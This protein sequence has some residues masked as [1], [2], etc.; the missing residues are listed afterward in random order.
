MKSLCDRFSEYIKDYSCEY[1]FDEPLKNHCTFR[2][3]GNA[4]ILFIP[5]D[6]EAL[7][8]AVLF[9]GEENCPLTILGN[10]S[11][12][13]ISD[14]GL[15]GITVR[16]TGGLT[17]M[18]LNEDG[19]VYSE[20]G[21]PL[22]KL[23]SFALEHSLSGLEF[24]YGIPGSVGGALYMNAGAYGGEIKSVLLSVRSMDKTTGEITDT[25]LSELLYE[26]RNTS[27]MKNGRIITGGTFRLI[28]SDRDTIS[29][30]MNSLMQKR[31]DRQPLNYPSAGSTFKRPPKDANGKEVYAAKLIEEA[32]LKGTFVGDAEVSKKHSG[33]IINKKNATFSDVTDLMELVQQKVYE[34]SGIML[35][36]EVE[37]LKN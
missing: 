10:G 12:V 5:Y 18:K 22:M 24:A 31:R 25:P 14:K 4:E 23:C 33:F 19:S 9:A 7:K 26:Y 13:L 30:E 15:N 2:I 3:G 28:P 29:A 32:G 17:Q 34:N 8:A 1:H 6:E 16:M 36:P 11:N 21:V 20:A 35:T 27:F 37:I